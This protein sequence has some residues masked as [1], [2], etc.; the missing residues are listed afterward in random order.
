MN[1]NFLKFASSN[2]SLL[3]K[4][5]VLLLVLLTF[6]QI[7]FGQVIID[8]G[9]S[10]I[11]LE[12][13]IKHFNDPTDTLSIDDF[14]K[15]SQ[16]YAFKNVPLASPN[17]GR[18]THNNWFV[19]EIKNTT[20]YSKSVYLYMSQPFIDFLNLYVIENQEVVKEATFQYEEKLKKGL[21]EHLARPTFEI[22]MAPNQRVKVYIRL[23]NTAGV[24][25][26]GMEL[27]GKQAFFRETE[28]EQNLYAIFFGT[29][30]AFSLI[31]IAF[32]AISKS[33][34]Y[35][36][37]G[38]YV[39]FINISFQ[40]LIGN[41]YNIS[42]FKLDF[43]NGDSCF[44][45]YSILG[46]VFN[47]FFLRALFDTPIGR[48]FYR[49]FGQIV[50]YL[51]YFVLLLTALDLGFIYYPLG[52]FL[53]TYTLFLATAFSTIICHFK[54][55]PNT[56][57]LYL[58]SFLPIVMV[59]IIRIL[60]EENFIETPLNFSH[61]VLPSL[62]FEF[63]ILLIGLSKI[64]IQKINE[65]NLLEAKIIT[66]Q[67]ETQEAER[68]TIAHNL[69][70]DLGSTLS[71]LKEQIYKATDNQ[72]TQKLINKAIDDLR[73]ISHNLLPADFEAFGFIPSLEKHIA[74]LNETAGLKI[75]FITFGESNVFSTDTELNIYRILVEILHNFKKHSQA[76][77]ATIQLVYH[78]DCLFVS[79]ENNEIQE[80][81]A[82]KGNGIGEKS[83]ISRLEYLH[84]RVL[85]K[86][87]KTNGY[88]YIFEIPYD[89]NLNR[90]RPSDF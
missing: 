88:S 44:R 86:G 25:I 81:N 17:I 69:H 61:F 1:F 9:F 42:S 90:G 59:L 37:Y 79:F 6:N 82:N 15:P 5:T 70:D 63:L 13:K 39:L 28:F 11:T 27:M 34:I 49:R 74:K 51:C 89:Q 65:K 84:A 41:L 75:T 12:N 76:K 36:Y 31:S 35:L 54:R 66:N 30:L 60:S 45:F 57:K 56:V 22:E 19:F 14:L 87:D 80:K 46:L 32:F 3:L 40:G 23:R 48:N 21:S 68:R 73:S 78:A 16:L 24:M 10:S 71:I 50:L 72:D 58:V 2:I 85:E 8:D 7:L 47:I 43:I 29:I 52:S 38:L 62:A 26:L 20:A 83:I 18:D 67:I 55:R 77:E 64:F 33:K 53:S 4:N